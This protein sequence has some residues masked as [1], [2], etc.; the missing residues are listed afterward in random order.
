MGWHLTADETALLA[1]PGPTLAQD[2]EHQRLLIVEH[3]RVKRRMRKHGWK[4]YPRQAALDAAWRELRRLRE[5]AEP[6]H[7]SKAL[8][9]AGLL[10]G[11]GS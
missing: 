5:K 2:I 3:E 8:R 11:G 10:P 9:S 7:I 6:T 4:H 1:A